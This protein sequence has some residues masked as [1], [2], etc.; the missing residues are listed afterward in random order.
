MLLTSEKRTL[1]ELGVLS[2]RR[3][4][5]VVKASLNAHSVKSMTIMCSRVLLSIK[6]RFTSTP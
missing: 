4:H 6:V 3:M 2:Q 1:V 5:A